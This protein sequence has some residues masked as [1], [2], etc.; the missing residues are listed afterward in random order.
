MHKTAWRLSALLLIVGTAAAQQAPRTIALDDASVADLNAAFNAGSVTSEQLVRAFLN[1]I[2]AYDKHGPT[3]RAIISLNPKA[4]EIARQL[5]H[6]RKTK[7][8]RSAL[9]GIPVV[10][11]DNIDTADMPTTAGSIMLA[12]SL[13]P[14][15]A[16]LVTRLRDAGAIILAKA[17]MSEFASGRAGSSL[18][19]PM[20]NP[21]DLARTPLGSSGGSA[22][23]VAAAYTVIA[24]GT[25]TGGSVR[26]P[27]STTG[28]VGLKPTYGLVS[29]DGVIPLAPTLDTVGPMARTV[30]DVAV[31]LSVIAGVDPK[32]T[33]TNTSAGHIERDYTKFLQVDALNGARIGVARDF[34]GFDPDVDW[35]AES[36]LAAI[37][38]AG[39]EVVDVRLPKW[40]LDSKGEFYNAIRYPEFAASIAGYLRTLGPAY[41]KNINQLISKATEINAPRTDGAG[42]NPHRWTMMKREAASGTLDDY[43]YTSVRDHALPTV[44]AVIEGVLKSEKLDAI[45]YPTQPRRA[46]LLATAPDAPGGLRESPVNLA[47]LAGFPDLTVPAGFTSDGVPVTISFLGAVFSEPRLLAIGYSFEQATRARRLPVNTPLDPGERIRIR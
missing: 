4:I 35:V 37:R 9:H 7:G 6:E 11:K 15:D 38:R 17:N 27:S 46:P 8:A 36:A 10:L 14:D 34:M 45:F 26:L 40:L 23:A 3:L 41:P 24:L 39:A 19:G 30:H 28:I 31:A 2:N 44:R 33:V 47:N 29:C 32:D 25:D 13:P 42:P 1:R 22:I 5:D 16:F 12:G 21:H 20:K 18:G 43:R